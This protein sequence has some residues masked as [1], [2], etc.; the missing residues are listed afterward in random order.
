MK[1]YSIVGEVEHRFVLPSI[2]GIPENV[3]LAIPLLTTDDEGNTRAFTRY[4][5][6]RVT[7]YRDGPQGEPWQR[8]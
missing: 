2:D 4:V 8:L 3:Q 7:E 1:I 6:L 5:N